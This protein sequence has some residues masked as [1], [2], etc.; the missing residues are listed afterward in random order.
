MIIPL[1]C[2]EAGKVQQALAPGA[3]VSSGQLLAK[4][5]LA[6]PG[7]VP[8]VRVFSGTY[9]LRDA[10]TQESTESTRGVTNSMSLEET[11]TSHLNGYGISPNTK[12]ATSAA[13]M[14]M[15]TTDES[16]LVKALLGLDH[17][18]EVKQS[19]SITSRLLECFLR[20]ETHFA[21]QMVNN[22]NQF[23]SK[24]AADSTDTVDHLLA[25]HALPQTRATVATVLRSLGDRIR[26]LDAPVEFPKDFV[27]LRVE[28]YSR[29]GTV[30]IIFNSDQNSVKIRS[31][32]RK[33]GR[34][35]AEIRKIQNCAFLKIFEYILRNSEK[36]SSKSPPNSTKI[37]E[38]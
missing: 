3:I 2:A 4:L 32:F 38:K 15:H 36:I 7:T 37:V 17:G 35:S 13:R 11:V 34:N 10:T 33:I 5:H 14:A 8:T 22:G 30:L 18:V 23:V 28:R 24:L 26:E 12:I 27:A 31:E 29:R 20:N 1:Q 25:H 19:I 6:D 9:P 21:D 16:L